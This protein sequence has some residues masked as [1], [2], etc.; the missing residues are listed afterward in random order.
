MIKDSYF[1][2]NNLKFYYTNYNLRY[3]GCGDLET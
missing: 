2:C 1:F 3:V